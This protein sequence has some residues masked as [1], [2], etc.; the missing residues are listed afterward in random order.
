VQAAVRLPAEELA[1]YAFH[2]LAQAVAL[3]IPRL[4]R[5]VTAAVG[6]QLAGRTAYLEH[7]LPHRG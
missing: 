6:A 3:L 2:D 1:S 7:G 5:R 4:G